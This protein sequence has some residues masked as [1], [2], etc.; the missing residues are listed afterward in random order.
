LLKNKDL[1][2]RAKSLL[3]NKDLADF[4]AKSLLKNKDLQ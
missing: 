2:W 4:F 1:P 3:K